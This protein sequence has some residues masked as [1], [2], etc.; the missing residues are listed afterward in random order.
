MASAYLKFESTPKLTDATLLV[1]LAGW[2]D[3]GLVSTGTVRSLMNG[4]ALTHIATI[5][6]D[7]FYI[8]NFPGSMEIA[9][10]FRPHVKY[11]Q[12]FITDLQV[13]ENVFHC[14]EANNLV[15]FIGQEPNLKWQAFADAI[16]ELAE[17]V[18]VKRIMFIGSFG[19][20]VPHTRDSRLFGSVSH[21][22]LR[23]RLDQH[24]VRLSDYE[25]PS[26]FSTLL[27]AQ[28]PKHDI[29][30]MSLVAE[31][32]GYLQGLNPLSIEAVTRR[33]SA[34]LDLPVDFDQLR[35]ASNE[36]EAEVS[37]AVEHDKK[38][39]ATVRKLEE[40]YDNELIGVVPED[41][42]EEE[43]EEHEGAE[44]EEEEE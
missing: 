8:Y 10:V 11:E 17:T 7:P 2:M 31:I 14:D 40:R 5:D 9:A 4:R 27:L 6:S 39:A 34:L 3:G 28:S 20:T 44:G 21:A 16:F 37:E 35:S 38:L 42:D 26:G 15:F 19:G 43:M 12:G 29:E 30:M 41:D 23:E 33:L 36:W 25:G 13:P 22:L 1:A 18:G 32:P 24:N